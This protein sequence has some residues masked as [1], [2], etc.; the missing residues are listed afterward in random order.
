MA[1]I[2]SG[3]VSVPTPGTAIQLSSTDTT[4]YQQVLVS[5]PTGNQGDIYIGDSTVSA[6]VGNEAGVKVSA[7]TQGWL[8]IATPGVLLSN[9]YVDAVNANDRVTFTALRGP[10]TGA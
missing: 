9:I 10:W 8:A 3:F 5:V 7:G 2:V 4:R 6:M 1:T